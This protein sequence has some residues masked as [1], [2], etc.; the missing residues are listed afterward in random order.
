MCLCRVPAETSA[1]L[2]DDCLKHI[3][4]KEEQ[5]WRMEV[6]NDEDR[7]QWETDSNFVFHL[8]EDVIDGVAQESFSVVG[9]QQFGPEYRHELLKIHLAVP[10]GKHTEKQGD[11]QGR[12]KIR[13][14]DRNA[15]RPEI[16]NA[17]YTEVYN[18]KCP[19]TDQQMDVPSSMTS[20]HAP[21]PLIHPSNQVCAPGR[22]CTC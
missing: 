20:L 14:T 6:I 3:Q 17:Y 18:G 21:S 11:R 13:Y 16:N 10:C 7:E 12:Y 15:D 8:P 22:A 1:V 2:E 4:S 19:E 5:A 9:R